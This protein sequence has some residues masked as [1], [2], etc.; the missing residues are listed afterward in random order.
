MAPIGQVAFSSP[1]SSHIT[2]L[3]YSHSYISYCHTTLTL[4]HLT[5]HTHACQ[6][7]S[8]SHHTTRRAVASGV[9]STCSSWA[10][11][12]RAVG[13]GGRLGPWAPSYGDLHSEPGARARWGW[14]SGPVMSC[15]VRLCHVVARG[16]LVPGQV[17]SYGALLWTATFLVASNLL[18]QLRD[19]VAGRAWKELSTLS[20]A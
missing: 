11:G 3:S 6:A 20:G 18:L 17:V 5:P 7:V 10:G 12:V 4:I 16:V 8:N 1:P 14:R 15:Y 19:Y 13:A 9:R 2:Y